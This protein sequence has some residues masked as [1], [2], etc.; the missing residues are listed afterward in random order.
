LIWRLKFNLSRLT[1]PSHIWESPLVPGAMLC[2]WLEETWYSYILVFNHE[3][4][5]YLQYWDIVVLTRLKGLWILISNSWKVLTCAY[6]TEIFF[7]LRE[8]I[9]SWRC[10]LP[11]MYKALGSI[12]S[13][14]KNEGK[15]KRYSDIHYIYL[16][17]L[18]TSF[19]SIKNVFQE[20]KKNTQR[21]FS[22]RY[23][24]ETRITPVSLRDMSL[25]MS[26]L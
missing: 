7:F 15:R 16:I 22:V 24:I 1:L 26:F 25:F 2:N 17:F 8:H 5:K 21:E 18:L 6:T 3:I 12:P 14:T 9:E 11:H 10:S 19:W 4:G 23:L 20:K 13:T